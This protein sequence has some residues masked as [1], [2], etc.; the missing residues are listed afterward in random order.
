MGIALI[1]VFMNSIEIL[2][3]RGSSQLVD[4]SDEQ[5]VDLST[6]LLVAGNSSIQSVLIDAQRLSFSTTHF[7][8][9]ILFSVTFGVV[10]SLYR[11][12]SAHHLPASFSEGWD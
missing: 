2:H 1:G 12:K 10:F 8:L 11:R 5:I 4:F 6:G 9:A 3:L 7:V